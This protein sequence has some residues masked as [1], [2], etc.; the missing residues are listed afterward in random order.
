MMC[1]SVMCMCVARDAESINNL[2]N[3]VRLYYATNFN[4]Y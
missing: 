1:A 3:D 2:S 4:I